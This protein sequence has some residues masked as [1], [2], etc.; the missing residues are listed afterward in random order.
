MLDAAD[1]VEYMDE[2][3]EEA[4]LSGVEEEAGAAVV[5]YEVA[6]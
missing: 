4:E 1:E 5:A 3:N 2:R 6:G